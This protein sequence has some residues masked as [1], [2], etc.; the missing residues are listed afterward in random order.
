MSFALVPE[1][2][3]SGDDGAGEP[4]S[5]SLISDVAAA[6]GQRTG[7][8]VG[9]IFQLNCSDAQALAQSICLPELQ[10]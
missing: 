5:V 7:A 10:G 9:S 4:A 2:D 3:A 1:V 8:L 6:G